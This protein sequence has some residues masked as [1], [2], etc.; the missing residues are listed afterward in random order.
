MKGNALNDVVI[1]KWNGLDSI[2]LNTYV[3]NKFLH[4][5]RSRRL[6]Y[7]D[8]ILETGSDLC[9]VRRRANNQNESNVTLVPF[10]PHTFTNRP[11]V[12]NDSLQ[13]S[14]SPLVANDTS[15]VAACEHCG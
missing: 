6:N 15:R 8:A 13:I 11:I 9:I 10:C 7:S 1:Q 5:Q 14:T 2:T 3:N 4:S 12:I